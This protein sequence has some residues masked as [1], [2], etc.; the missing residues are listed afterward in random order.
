MTTETERTDG[1]LSRKEEVSARRAKR[2]KVRQHRSKMA[3]YGKDP[4]YEYRFVRDK[5]ES[6]QTIRLMM[7][8]D[9]ELV[10]AKELDNI[11]DEDIHKSKFAGGS[12]VRMPSGQDGVF[13]YLMKIRKDFYLDDQK[14]KQDKISEKE[15]QMFT[16]LDKNEYDPVEKE[17]AKP[18][19]IH[20]VTAG[21]QRRSEG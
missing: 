16:S 11:G 17:S 10:K 19:G 9:W 2:T 15:K 4:N 14:L 8:D 12:I 21:A 3:V 13:Q 6:G 20:Q 1:Q 18:A 7:Q 5:T